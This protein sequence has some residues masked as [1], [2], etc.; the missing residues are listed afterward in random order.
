MKLRAGWYWFR[1]S[2]AGWSPGTEKAWELR[3][4]LG[5]RSKRNTVAAT[6]WSNGCWHTWDRNG[7]GGENSE[8]KDVETAKAEV[9]AALMRQARHGRRWHA[10]GPLDS[11]GVAGAAA[12]GRSNT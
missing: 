11:A 9:L 6:V 5:G 4:P 7:V 1:Y 2:T 3:A 10:P 12:D 8:D